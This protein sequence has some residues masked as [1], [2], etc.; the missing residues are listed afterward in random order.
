[1]EPHLNQNVLAL[2]C[3]PSGIILKVLRNDF[4]LAQAENERLWIGLI[5]PGSII[6]GLNFWR[7]IT[8][9]GAAYDWELN[10]NRGEQMVPLH[11]AG[12]KVNQWFLI[13]GSSGSTPMR[14]YEEE[15]GKI[16]NEYTNLLRSQI[17]TTNEPSHA[18]LEEVTRLNNELM[19]IQRELTKTISELSEKQH[20]IQRIFETAPNVLLIYDLVDQITVFANREIVTILG[21]TP[22]EIQS[23]GPSFLRHLV[24]PNDA[25]MLDD[26]FDR[27]NTLPSGETLEIEYR[28]RDAAGE[29]RWINSRDTVFLRD[30][31]GKPRQILSIA[32]DVTERKKVQE[33]LW[34]LSTHDALTG[35]YNRGYFHEEMTRY[36]KT[37]AFPI[38]ILIADLDNLKQTNDTSGHTAGDDLLRRAAN[39]LRACFRPGEVIA[40]VGGDEFAVLLEHTPSSAAQTILDRI[41]RIVGAESIANEGPQLGM[42]I[43]IATAEYAQPL[44]E[45][46]KQADSQM[47]SDKVNRKQTGRL[48]GRR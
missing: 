11:F 17:Q 39:V 3:D 45:I 9:K 36:E 34:Y 26:H 8:E 40:R 13:V 46:Y 30:T 37:R 44:L 22:S 31:Q 28:L 16:L 33:K 18:Y 43:G 20:F 41:Q 1:M 12:G 19:T 6:K 32:Q 27:F 35:L 2:L 15:M 21:Y 48:R 38:S 25:A 4:S 47:Y 14:Y 10:I 24:H 29:W 23:M 7:E 42:S 5:E